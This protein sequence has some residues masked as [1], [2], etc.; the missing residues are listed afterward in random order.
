MALA[1]AEDPLDAPARDRRRLAIILMVSQNREC[2]PRAVAG[3]NV[4]N[5]EIIHT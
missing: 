4:S 2:D 3:G 1:S 5:I